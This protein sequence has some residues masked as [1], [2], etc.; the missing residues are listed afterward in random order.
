[1]NK[2]YEEI[3]SK[4]QS[5]FKALAKECVQFD[6]ARMLLGAAEAS[7][8]LTRSKVSKSIDTEWID[9]IEATMPI[10]DMIIRN[11]SVTIEDVDEILPVELSRHITE[12]SIKHLAQ[13]TNLILD[14]KDDEVI[15]QKILNVFHE[16][17]LL[18]YENKFVN[19]LLNRLSAFVDK[20]LR[21]LNGTLGVEM[22][23]KFGYSTE[24]EHFISDEGGR[25]SAR[26][27]LQIELTSPL[28]REMSESDKEINERYVSALERA[29]RINMALI[30][31]GSSAFVQRL[32]RN[33]VR[34]PI[35]RTNAILR[36]KNLK[37]C[38]NLW[39]FIEG[40]DKVG[41]TFVGDRAYELP[42]DEFVGGMYSAAA[43][44]YLTLYSGVAE[45]A[46]NT[47][48]ISEKHLFDVLPEFD[49]D[50]ESEELDDYQVYDSEY[51]KTV[52]VS[53]LMNN[54]KKLS[55]DEK[56]IRRALLIALRAD[57]IMNEAQVREEME[58]RR[59]AREAEEER[60]RLEEEARRLAE[61][62]AARLAEEARLAAMREVEVRYRRS[63]MSRYIQAESYIQE[64]YNEI[65]NTLLSYKGVKA[66][67]SWSKESFKRG[68][69][70]LA[71]IDVK[72]K[73]LYLYLA[74]EPEE[75]DAKY[76]ATRASGDCPTLI[77]IKSPRRLK[78]SLELIEALMKKLEIPRT[79]RAAED[80][81]LPYEETE[82]LIERGLIKVILPKGEVLDENAIAVKA[83]LSELE[84]MRAEAEAKRK[85]LLAAEEA[86]NEA[87]AVESTEVAE[88]ETEVA[89]DAENEAE[90]TDSTEAAEAETEVAEEAE[91]E[92]EAAESTEAAEAETEVAEEAE[93][94]AE[95]VE[96]T[97]VA[98]AETE[99]A[100]E[101]E[102]EATKADS[103]IEPE[104]PEEFEA[105]ITAEGEL[106]EEAEAEVELA[107]DENLDSICGDDAVAI[108]DAALSIPEEES[109][110]E[111]K[112]DDMIRSAMKQGGGVCISLFSTPQIYRGERGV[113]ALRFAFSG[114]ARENSAQIVIPYTREQYL[115]LPRKK[116]K[117]V[118]M[119][120]KALLRYK[121][122]SMLLNKLLSL[123]SSSERIT[124]RIEALRERLESERKFLPTSP[125]WEN[126]VKR[127][128][129]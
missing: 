52:P 47:R 54:R 49:S 8:S 123:N 32:G 118:L 12:K 113:G 78:Q 90:A 77:K 100:E 109:I 18:T 38:L 7:T 40:Y 70:H 9:R 6:D 65:K 89:E 82:A 61:M 105:K 11:P 110:P 74:L 120:V 66:R 92:A 56:K 124:E 88:F 129:K 73:A 64:Y 108:A 19:T 5:A 126:A 35:I 22:N 101:A 98:E 28:G 25:N 93:N 97:E 91:N 24:F 104:A 27:N 45:D 116:K 10:L 119:N 125:L 106:L 121:A 68:R 3:K 79:E 41:Y 94:E 13:H 29:R 80:Y 46:E 55:E 128:S 30:S 21:A 72:G 26:I 81:R 15:P 103:A 39:E 60:R 33:F 75:L 34:P 50:I 69:A 2:L 99:V 63:F 76:F 83:D 87:D 114:G 122:T 43:L 23:Y 107:T 59:L 42:S 115:A 62:E 51:R 58:K 36:N 53:R 96:S 44:Q 48:L 111:A 16:E 117:R 14:V 85:E 20:R 1:M 86:E 4:A 71:K 95:A 31:Y 17:T 67:S 37:E 57:E 127:I 112:I 102:N 84:A